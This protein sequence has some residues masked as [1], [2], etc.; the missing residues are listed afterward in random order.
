M[1]TRLHPSRSGSVTVDGREIPF[2]AGEPF[3]VTDAEAALLDAEDGFTNPEP[4]TRKKSTP[5]GSE[6]VT[7]EPTP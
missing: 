5:E 7:Q 4:K 1:P 2:K 6:P 3:E